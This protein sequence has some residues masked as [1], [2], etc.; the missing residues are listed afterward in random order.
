MLTG[1][2][3]VPWLLV[4]LVA[5]PG[6]GSLLQLALARTREFDADLDA[7]GLTG[8]PVGLAAALTKLE[9]YQGRFWQDIV[10]PGRR[11][12]DPSILRS[13]PATEE[14]VRRLAELRDLAPAVPLPRMRD[15]FHHHGAVPET[16]PKPRWRKSGLWY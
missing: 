6:I 13:H 9:C 14:R 11:I 16:P 12:P 7:I 4:L 1:A 8:D 10:L 15:T 5:A 3:Q 2:D